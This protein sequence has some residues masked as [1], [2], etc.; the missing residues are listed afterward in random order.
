MGAQSTG[1]G[2]EN[3]TATGLSVSAP[4][5]TISFWVKAGD[6]T[7]YRT[8]LDFYDNAGNSSHK[9]QQRGDDT[10]DYIRY[11]CIATG[12][13]GTNA[14]GEDMS[15]TTTWHN[16][17]MIAAANN[18]RRVILDGDW[19]NSTQS[20]TNRV[21][22]GLDDL[23]LFA[24]EGGSSVETGYLAEVCIWSAALSQANAESLWTSSE[25]GPAPNTVDS[26][27]VVHYWTLT[28]TDTTTATTGSVN[29]TDNGINGFVSDHPTISGGSTYPVNPMGHPLK[30]ALGGPVG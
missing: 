20:T 25:T 6:L 22:S 11:A 21:T 10:G 14:D 27:N 13:G 26:G 12:G 18:D 29:L 4:P 2:G 19:T 16:V 24:Q 23:I 28:S 5:F 8:F 1:T 15:D 9:L 17:T 3:L 7:N 30:G